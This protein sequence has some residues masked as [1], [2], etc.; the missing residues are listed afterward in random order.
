MPPFLDRKAD[1]APLALRRVCYSRRRVVRAATSVRRQRYWDNRV[2]KIAE[3]LAS[4]WVDIRPLLF[5]IASGG[6]RE[7]SV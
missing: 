4:D 7:F 5:G 3:G 2:C 1:P 6:V